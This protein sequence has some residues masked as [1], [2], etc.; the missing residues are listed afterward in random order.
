[1][2]VGSLATGD[3]EVLERHVGRID[4]NHR[5]VARTCVVDRAAGTDS[6][7]SLQRVVVCGTGDQQSAIET[8][9]N[10]TAGTE[11]HITVG[12]R[13]RV[14]GPITN[15]CDAPDIA[16]K[17]R[18]SGTGIESERLG[19]V[20]GARNRDVTSSTALQHD[21]GGQGDTGREGDSGSDRSHVGT[22]ADQSI[23]VLSETAIGRDIRPGSDR[24]Q[25]AAVVGQ[26]G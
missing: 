14:R 9:H 20:E 18:R 16:L 1:M 12:D 17:F 13:D 24:Q 5:R 8:D 11:V 21:I 25:A 10:R 3:L 26:G 19:T 7:R 22:Q 23:T 6:C 15:R 2:T 4:L